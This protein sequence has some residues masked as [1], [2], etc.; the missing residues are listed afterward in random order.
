MS[1]V[2]KFAI[3]TITNP[4]PIYIQSHT[5]QYRYSSFR[6]SSGL[7]ANIRT[8]NIFDFPQIWH[9]KNLWSVRNKNVCRFLVHSVRVFLCICLCLWTYSLNFC[10]LFLVSLF[11]KQDNASTLTLKPVWRVLVRIFPNLFKRNIIKCVIDCC[12]ITLQSLSR[13]ILF[14]QVTKTYQFE[15]RGVPYKYVI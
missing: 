5:R 1:C 12:N 2:L 7:V 9:F 14:L 8:W 3:N 15:R 6:N 13:L 11:S 4:N 10:N